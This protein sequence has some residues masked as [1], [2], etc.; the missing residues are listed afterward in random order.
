M[1]SNYLAYGSNLHPIRLM[2]RV[3]SARLVG[4]T[5]VGGVEL[6]F[7]KKSKDGSG[8]CNLFEVDE[9]NRSVFAAVYQI[10]ETEKSAL[11]R[12][13][14]KGSGYFDAAISVNIN[15]ET[16]T[17]FTYRAQKSHIV[18]HLKPYH[19]YKEMVLVGAEF[20]QFPEG[21]I[22]AVRA[23]GSV[24]D[25]DSERRIQNEALLERMRRFHQARGKIPG[26]A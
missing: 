20:L 13:E 24:Q 11:D 15:G 9:D 17:C 18:D 8:K 14:G 5:E 10:E 7:H 25:R 6:A 12:A 26:R 19:W 3:P 16:H 1:H 23:I 4:I 21:Y 22:E 2:E